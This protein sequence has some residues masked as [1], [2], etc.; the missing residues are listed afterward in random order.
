MDEHIEYED[1]F[2]PQGML[3]EVSKHPNQS[4]GRVRHLAHAVGFVEESC[5][6]NRW[7]FTMNFLKYP[8]LSTS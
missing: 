4:Q 2:T 5:A 1:I 7:C 8:Q 6:G 3:G